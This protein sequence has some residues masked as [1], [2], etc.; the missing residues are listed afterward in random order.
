MEFLKYLSPTS[1]TAKRERKQKLTH[2]HPPTAPKLLV[3]WKGCKADAMIGLEAMLRNVKLG[4]VWHYQ[5]PT[6]LCVTYWMELEI[7]RSCDFGTV[8]TV[9]TSNRPVTVTKSQVIKSH[10]TTNLNS[11]PPEYESSVLP[12]CHLAWFKRVVLCDSIKLWN[13]SFFRHHQASTWA[14]RSMMTV[15][16][17]L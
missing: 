1:R 16:H 15:K 3:N 8:V 17:R 6:S 10:L 14:T 4:A 2:S 7:F 5:S 12:L 9:G 13:S 11:G